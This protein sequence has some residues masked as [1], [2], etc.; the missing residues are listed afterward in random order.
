MRFSTHISITNAHILTHTHTHLPA[1]TFGLV[2][3]PL[4][5][6]RAFVNWHYC[7]SVC[8]QIDSFAIIAQLRTKGQFQKE[9]I[10]QGK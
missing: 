7:V 9:I 2:M 1:C 3:C 10:T 8:G 4:M 6:L 5:A